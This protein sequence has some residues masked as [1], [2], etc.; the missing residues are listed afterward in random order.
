MKFRS[1]KGEVYK[2]ERKGKATTV[3]A[4]LEADG[5]SFEGATVLDVG[6][7]NGQIGGHL[8]TLGAVVYGVDV[9]DVRTNRTE[10]SPHFTLIESETLPFP[11]EF[12]DVVVSH[13]VVEHVDDRDAHVAEIWRVLRRGGTA[14][15][16]CPNATSPIMEGHV[17]VSGVPHWAEMHDLFTGP[18]FELTEHGWRA[19]IDPDRYNVSPRFGKYLPAP[20]AKAL[21]PWFPSHIFTARKP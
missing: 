12:F 8:Q 21:R 7:G 4:A 14:Y 6:H 16:A 15:F 9:K 11:D 1:G 5:V 2:L 17:G 10:D 20:V 3:V 18:G 13:H 19:T